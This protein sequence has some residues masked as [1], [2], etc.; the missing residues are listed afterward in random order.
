MDIK[1]ELVTCN[2]SMISLHN[3]EW[4]NFVT[5]TGRTKFKVWQKI[6]ADELISLLPG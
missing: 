3:P 1:A 4:P 2:H 5:L 6:I